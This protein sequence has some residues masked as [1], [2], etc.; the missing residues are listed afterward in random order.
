MS[1]NR[2]DPETYRQLFSFQHRELTQSVIPFPDSLSTEPIADL[3]VSISFSGDRASKATCR[4]KIGKQR[5]AR[6][7]KSVR[8]FTDQH[9]KGQIDFEKYEP[10]NPLHRLFPQW[11]REQGISC[12]D[13]EG[14][15]FELL[16]KYLAPLL[17]PKTKI[18]VAKGPSDIFQSSFPHRTWLP[19]LRSIIFET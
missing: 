4:M 13:A 6:L 19:R 18:F 10:M 3:G 2:R 11:Q 14:A 12:L 1:G 16:L 5:T 17:V 15:T 7:P 8:N 9:L